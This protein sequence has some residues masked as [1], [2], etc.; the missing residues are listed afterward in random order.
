MSAPRS[1]S[2]T[3]ILALAIASQA[4]AL[5]AAPRKR[6]ALLGNRVDTLYFDGFAAVLRLGGTPDRDAAT[7][8]SRLNLNDQENQ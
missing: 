1:L 4:H 5:C 7:G 3:A 6:P 8:T 2:A